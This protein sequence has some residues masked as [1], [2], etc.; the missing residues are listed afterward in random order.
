MLVFVCF[1]F[2]TLTVISY[3]YSYSFP[4]IYVTPITTN[5]VKNVLVKFSSDPRVCLFY[6]KQINKISFVGTGKKAEYMC[7]LYGVQEDL[8]WPLACFIRVSWLHL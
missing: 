6:L 7:T 2:S 4:A 1:Y 8:F 5:A 3:K